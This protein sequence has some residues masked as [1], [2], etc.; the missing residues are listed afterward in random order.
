M[1]TPI[2]TAFLA[3]LALLVFLDRR[4]WSPAQHEKLRRVPNPPGWFFAVVWTVLYPAIFFALW[5][6]HTHRLRHSSLKFFIAGFAGG[7]L[8]L[9][10][11]WVNVFGY[12]LATPNATAVPSF[13]VISACTASAVAVSVLFAN[14][15]SWVSFVC[16]T[17]YS[18]WLVCA[19]ALNSMYLCLRNPYAPLRR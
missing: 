12:Y 17:V 2:A 8:L 4:P 6:W 3:G 11:A 16:W 18:C 13:L 1:S 9:N 19:T 10:Y 14:E 7:N 5:Y 15:Q